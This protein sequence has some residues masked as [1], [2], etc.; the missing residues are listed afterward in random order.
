MPALQDLSDRYRGIAEREK[1]RF[2][3]PFRW[4]I[5]M[6]YDGIHFAD[7]GHSV[8]ATKI[9]EAV[10]EMR[11]IFSHAHTLNISRFEPFRPL[12]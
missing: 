1:I 5:P 9:S 7:E 8:F 4:D 2:A 11:F 6:A 3:D 10:T 12:S